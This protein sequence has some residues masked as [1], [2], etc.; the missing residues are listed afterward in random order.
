MTLPTTSIRTATAVRLRDLLLL[1]P[2]SSDVP[3]FVGWSGSVPTSDPYI[4]I[5][6]GNDTGELERAALSDAR[7]LRDDRWTLDVVVVS[8]FTAAD[9]AAEE[10]QRVENLAGVV[11]TVLAENPVLMLEGNG[12]PG[13]IDC[14]ARTGFEGPAV[15]ANGGD[16]SQFIAGCLLTLYCR[17]RLS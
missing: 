1:E 17:A 16:G 11:Q 5:Y 15:A 7:H 3:V 8:A 12:L 4:V 13:L 2:E 9:D 10:M 14:A 6:V